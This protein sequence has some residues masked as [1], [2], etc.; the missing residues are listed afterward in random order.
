MAASIDR[1]TRNR[2][3]KKNLPTLNAKRRQNCSATHTHR[4]GART[5]VWLRQW[6][7]IN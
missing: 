5:V 1:K 6:G 3:W 2:Y 7:G 4:S